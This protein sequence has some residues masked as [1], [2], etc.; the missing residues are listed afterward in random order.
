MTQ[1]RANGRTSGRQNDGHPSNE[2]AIG[3]RECIFGFLDHRQFDS[4]GFRDTAKKIP[5]G[6][7]LPSQMVPVCANEYPNR[8]IKYFDWVTLRHLT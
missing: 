5:N 2:H 1:G 8:Q 4:F 6:P 3:S 7:R